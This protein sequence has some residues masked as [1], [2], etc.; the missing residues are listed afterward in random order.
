MLNEMSML[1]GET[2]KYNNFL[3]FFFSLQSYI[4]YIRAEEKYIQRCSCDD[5]FLTS[6][7]QNSFMKL[8]SDRWLCVK[9]MMGEREERRIVCPAQ[10]ARWIV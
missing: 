10:E 7:F 6:T 9:C 3:L 4:E 2:K 5:S 8:Q 1:N